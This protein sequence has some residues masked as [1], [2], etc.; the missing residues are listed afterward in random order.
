[1]VSTSEGAAAALE[2]LLTVREV[3]KVL[4]V[5][6]STVYQACAD[7]KLAHVRVSNA[8]RVRPDGLAEYLA[9]REAPVR[10]SGPTCRFGK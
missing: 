2:P 9:R 5:A 10:S 4:Q 8:I 7:G 6:T 3:A 1:L